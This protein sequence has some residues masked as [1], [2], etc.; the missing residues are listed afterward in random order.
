MGDVAVGV[1]VDV[2]R[3]AVGA[4]RDHHGGQER[5]AGEDPGHRVHAV[6]ALV[7]RV[8]RAVDRAAA[9]QIDEFRH[10]QRLADQIGAARQ[11]GAHA[12]ALGDVVDAVRLHRQRHRLAVQQEVLQRRPGIVGRLRVPHLGEVVGAGQLG[13]VGQDHP[14]AHR[15]GDW[16]RAAVED[17]RRC[18]RVAPG[19]LADCGHVD[20]RQQGVAVQRCYAVCSPPLRRRDRRDRRRL[21]A[22]QGGHV[23][24]VARLACRSL[25]PDRAGGRRIPGLPC[26]SL[27]PD[28]VDG[29]RIARLP[30]LRLGRQCRGR[31]GVARL[32]RLALY[33]QRRGA[34]T[35]PSLTR[36]D[37]G[38]QRPPI[39]DSA[40]NRAERHRKRARRR[41]LRRRQARPDRV[42]HR[43]VAKRQGAG[44]GSRAAAR[45]HDD[46]RG[47]CR[48]HAW[49]RMVPDLDAS[50]IGDA[51]GG[52]GAGPTV[53]GQD[54]GADR[55]PGNAVVGRIL[56]RGRR[57]AGDLACQRQ[58]LERCCHGHTE[59]D[60]L[61]PGVAGWQVDLDHVVA[62]RPV[63]D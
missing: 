1:D 25:C 22:R 51:V 63:Q 36:G 9:V 32:T 8:G 45:D 5:V 56:Q 52:P 12:V 55:L 46:E 2:Q 6:V 48:D 24:R 11:Q 19:Q 18:G 50:A 30:R 29:R 21:H 54:V 59:R 14:R 37:L 27:G 42:D 23:C 43:P 41:P 17:R 49:R 60:R 3:P 28:R 20:R 39:G 40:H 38:R 62:V 53:A 33:P 13:P 34:G 57:G 15:G 61:R 44:A 26:R 35:L 58:R 10:H 4:R 31:R 47:R 16:H 7:A